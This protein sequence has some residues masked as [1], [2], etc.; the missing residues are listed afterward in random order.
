MYHYKIAATVGVQ[1]SRPQDQSQQHSQCPPQGQGQGVCLTYIIMY[2]YI[3]QAK[4]LLGGL[5]KYQLTILYSVSRP[6]IY[7]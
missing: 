4:D 2:W 3:W 6:Y 1:G 5:T 7:V